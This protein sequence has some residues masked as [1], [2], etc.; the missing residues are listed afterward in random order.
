MT[1]RYDPFEGM[2]RFFDQ[3]RQSMF[4]S[5]DTN[6]HVERTDNGYVVMADLP[7]FENEDIDV[8]FDDGVLTI[9]GETAVAG[10]NGPVSHRRSRTVHE[11]LSIPGDV[12]IEDSDATYHNGVLEI[13]LPVDDE[14]DN[15]H[16]IDVE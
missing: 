8:Q 13:T 7:G 1:F 4:D 3:T 6:V 16:H 12:R 14:R 10:E 2:S 9:E 5:L 15:A 11:R